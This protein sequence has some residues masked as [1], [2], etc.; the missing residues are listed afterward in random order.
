M[1]FDYVKFRRGSTDAF[2]ALN[3]KDPNTLYFVYE[4]PAAKKGLLY[5]GDK[6]IGGGKFSELTDVDTDNAQPGDILV[7][8]NI[9][10]EQEPEYVWQAMDPER[11]PLIPDD[12]ILPDD[13]NLAP[14][15]TLSQAIM[16]L[17]E[18]ISNIA[19][20][21]SW[22]PIYVEGVQQLTDSLDSGYVNFTAGVGIALAASNG[23]INISVD[24]NALAEIIE[25]VVGEIVVPYDGNKPGLVPEAPETDPQDPSDVPSNYVLA[26]DGTW[27]NINNFGPYWEELS[28]VVIPDFTQEYPIDLN[29]YYIGAPLEVAEGILDNMG[30]AHTAVQSDIPA[31]EPNQ[32]LVVVDK[33]E[34]GYYDV[35]PSSVELKYKADEPHSHIM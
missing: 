16:K 3:P 22:R 11:L 27:I 6:L 29:Y 24:A 15:D 35:A 18:A 19:D 13:S 10:T 7:Y 23:T 5:L 12:A 31:I 2:S 32:T 33:D 26:G 17:D 21:D 9:G 20:T 4:N 1:A 30:I 34:V 8:V 14:G 28:G 25:Q